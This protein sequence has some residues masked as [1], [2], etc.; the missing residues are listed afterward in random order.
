MTAKLHVM[1]LPTSCRL[2]VGAQS[3][4]K[5]NTYSDDNDFVAM[6]GGGAPGSFSKIRVGHRTDTLQGMN[7]CKHDVISVEL[8][9]DQKKITFTIT[10]NGLQVSETIKSSHCS[11]TWSWRTSLAG[12][13]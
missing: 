12:I 6:L 1:S 2:W 10:K 11:W 4:T 7:L 9:M 5:P 13:E 8:D 3:R